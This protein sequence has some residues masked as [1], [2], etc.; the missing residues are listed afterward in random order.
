MEV[1]E[2]VEIA[3]GLRERPGK[4]PKR[5]LSLEHIVEAAIRVGSAEGLAAVS[6][7]KIAA[8]LDVSTMALYRY[9]TSK[10]DLLMLITNAVIGPPPQLPEPGDDWRHGV[11]RWAGALRAALQRHP[12]SL[13]I[14]ITGPGLMPNHVAWM[15][16]GLRCLRGTGLAPDT[17]MAALLLVDGFVRTEVALLADLQDA[18]DASRVTDEEAMSG[19]GRSLARL[20]DAQRFP[21]I[22]ELLEARVF[23]M[24]GGPDDEFVFGMDRILDG[25]TVLVTGKPPA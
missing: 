11:Y 23:D 1:P 21:E 15:E 14:P 3:W 10:G 13:R 6:M 25:L 2:S 7:S 18:F 19:Y 12:W 24:P 9:V 4:G 8:E 22:H 17:K 20:T 5:T 16:A